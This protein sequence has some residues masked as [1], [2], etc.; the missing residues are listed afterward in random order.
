MT[1]RLFSFKICLRD[2]E[3]GPRPDTCDGHARSL[4]ILTR[5]Q[6]SQHVADAD[7]SRLRLLDQHILD[8]ARLVNAF[9]GPGGHG[10]FAKQGDRGKGF[11]ESEFGVSTGSSLATELW[12]DAEDR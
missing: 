2:G 3:S 4:D 8:F 12:R 11:E 10:L 5:L 1:V 6:I 7:D 9:V